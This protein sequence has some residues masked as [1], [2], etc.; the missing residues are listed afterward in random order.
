MIYV[1]LLGIAVVGFGIYI[2]VVFSAIPG[3]VDERLGVFDE[4]PESLGTWSED[5]A[6]AEGIKDKQS[7]LVRETRFLLQRSTGLF[8]RETLVKQMRQRDAASGEVVNVLPEQ[9]I[10]RRRKRA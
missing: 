8:S 4:L 3:A 9:R 10:P 5:V 6:S 2:S 1:L 7:G